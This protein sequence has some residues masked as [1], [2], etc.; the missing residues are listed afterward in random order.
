MR[1]LAALLVLPFLF[2]CGAFDAIP[3]A[4]KVRLENETTDVIVTVS[5]QVTPVGLGP[6]PLVELD[7]DRR[8]ETGSA[9]EWDDAFALDNGDGLVV[10]VGALSAGQWST[11]TITTV[12]EGARALELTHRFD[13]ARA[14]FGI[15]WR[16]ASF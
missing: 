5:Y 12:G 6:K 16:W 14:D 2:A 15:R 10:R 3:T 13:T 4:V 1:A 9:Y 7:R 8:V 11:Y